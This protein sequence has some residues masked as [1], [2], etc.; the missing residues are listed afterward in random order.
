MLAVYSPRMGHVIFL[1]L[2][3]VGL[4]FGLWIL[5]FTIPLHL[6]YGAVRRRHEPRPNFWTHVPAFF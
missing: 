2:H 3:I 4:W 5:L 1:L 6:I